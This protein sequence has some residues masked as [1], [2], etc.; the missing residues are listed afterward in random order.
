MIEIK[1]ECRLNAVG[2]LK[3][4]HSKLLG[5][6]GTSKFYCVDGKLWKLAPD[7][8]VFRS[9]HP[10]ATRAILAQIRRCERFKAAWSRSNA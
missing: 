4:R 2:M 9:E 3:S 6:I 5:M 8:R 10:D 7:G 1:P